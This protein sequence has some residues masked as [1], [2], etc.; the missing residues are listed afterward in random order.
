M[1]LT[2]EQR[3]LA[4]SQ[5]PQDTYQAPRPNSFG[6]AAAASANQSVKQVGVA[7]KAGGPISKSL[8]TQA[9]SSL[10]GATP[11]PTA[12]PAPQP[13]GGAAQALSN[14]QAS[15]KVSFDPATNTYSGGKVSGDI[16]INGAAPSAPTIG[17]GQGAQALSTIPA[18]LS[19]PSLAG[20]P[21]A[22]APQISTPMVA[23]S[24]NDWAA[25]KQLENLATSASSITNTA[26]WGGLRRGESTPQMAAYQQ[27]LSTD[28]ALQQ[29]QPR[30][31]QA[32]LQGNV[33]LQQSSMREQGADARARLASQTDLT[34]ARQAGQVAMDR[35]LVETLGSVQAAQTKAN[36]AQN[37]PQGYRYTAG[38]NLQAIPG[39]PADPAA[40]K[41]GLQQAKDSQDVFS[42]I[43]QAKPLLDTSTNS[44]LGAAVDQLA[45]TAGV[46]TQGAQ[47][48]AQLKALQGALVSK[49]PKMSGPQSDKDVQLY[50]E[51]AGQIGDPTI[52]AEQR[53]SAMQTVESLNMKYLPVAGDAS[54]YQAL[55]SGSYY[56]TP[57]GSV[58]RKQ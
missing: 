14:V 19:Q 22:P 46:A 57:D 23:N 4:L 41:E 34:Q 37:A 10:P 26:K 24:T 28:A 13:E 27:A 40:S 6:D 8:G 45:R 1:A 42:I 32:A 56:K 38:G 44:Y 15:N 58:R 3:A 9:L 5:I 16:S 54:A 36:A 25:R 20:S 2:D 18:A 47:S 12:S 51:M 39:G 33:D 49:M 48:A 17:Q 30:M 31:D 21:T 35:T 11:T 50:R 29:A 52:P 43:D 53:R 7:G 55:Q